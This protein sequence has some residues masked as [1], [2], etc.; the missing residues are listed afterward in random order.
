MNQTCTIQIHE[1]RPTKEG[2]G[3]LQDSLKCITQD[4]IFTVT[5]NTKDNLSRCSVNPL[6]H[7]IAFSYVKRY[8]SGEICTAVRAIGVAS[9]I[10]WRIECSSLSGLRGSRATS[11]KGP[12]LVRGVILADHPVGAGVKDNSR[13][14]LQSAA[15]TKETNSSCVRKQKHTTK[16]SCEHLIP[17]YK[18]Y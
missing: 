12:L 1:P 16:S 8:T 3:Q 7:D 6:A 18:F 11:E 10:S 14:P 5:C 15:H 9:Q 2:I 13:R 17:A 4:S